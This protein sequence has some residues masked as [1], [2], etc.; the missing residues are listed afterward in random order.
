MKILLVSNM[1][2]SINAKNYGVFVQNTE[3][4]LIELG[5]SIEKI[6]LYKETN[7]FRKL[8]NYFIYYMKILYKGYFGKYDVLY[9][10]Y[11]SHNA[12]PLLLLLKLKRNIKIYTNVHGS[13]VIPENKTQSKLQ[14]FVK[15]LLRKSE[16]VITPSNYFKDLII[17]KYLISDK[18]IIVY[19]SGGVNN[20][21]FHPIEA[22]EELYKIYNLDSSYQYIGYVGRID[23]KKGWDVLLDSIKLLKDDN[24][25]TDKKIIIVGNGSQINEFFQKIEFLGIKEN[26]VYFD[27]LNQK[28]LNEI[29][30][31]L[32]IFCFPTM[33]EGESLG[34]VGIEAMAC[35]V[36]VIG[37]KIGGLT[38]YIIN[39]GNGYYFEV[40]NSSDLQ[41]KIIEYFNNSSKIKAGMKKTCIKTSENYSVE[42]I[43]GILKEIFYV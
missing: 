31:L 3:N 27:F 24:L 33:R 11:A 10:H 18:N 32:E 5:H 25:L 1:Y 13:D 34:L 29:Y 9:V 2:P 41:N 16:K 7:K 35:G 19:P 28:E 30:N 38:D 37:S 21:V 26:I 23:Y 8:I 6:I 17:K 42:S 15:K 4:S 22:K 12:L 36:P 20:K 40:G 14:V 43:R 39:G